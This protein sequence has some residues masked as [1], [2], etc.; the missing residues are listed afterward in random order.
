[1]RTLLHLSVLAILGL[2]AIAGCT[3]TS[4]S[5]TGQVACEPLAAVEQPIAL[6]KVLAVGMDDAGTLYLVDQV[7]YENRVFQ[8]NGTELRLTRQLGSGSGTQADGST[9]MSFLFESPVDG[10][11]H[12]LA[13][14]IAAG[15]VRMAYA[16]S[17]VPKAV[18]DSTLAVGQ[19]LLILDETALQELTLR[20]LP[21]EIVV[22]YNALTSDGDRIV[23]T[24]PR[25]AWT[26]ED[27][28]L[29]YGE[30]DTLSECVVI[31][32]TR[33]KDGG[34][35]WI[36]FELAGVEV[37]ALFPASIVGTPDPP[38]LTTADRVSELTELGATENL[39]NLTFSC[40]AP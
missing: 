35:T 32:T 18:F 30:G 9:F 24:R 17:E 31:E 29:F 40:L 36:R 7:G 13:V 39:E 23:V 15:V 20:N 19:E 28:R 1:M 26:Y 2:P 21:G 14:D 34:T 12:T 27:F 22:E 4:S 37:T 16:A 11:T 8:S 3:E 5:S 38:T 6:G 10:A 25:D 33:A